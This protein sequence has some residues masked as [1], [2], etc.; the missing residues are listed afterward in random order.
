MVLVILQELLYAIGRFFI[1]PL[2]YVAI[3]FAIFLG[4]RRVKRERKFFHIRIVNGWSE[5]KSVFKIG[6]FASILLSI[7]MIAAGLTL[8]LEL[9]IAISVVTTVMVILFNF[10]F[11]SAVVTWTIAYSLLIWMHA[12][13]SSIEIVGYT[14]TGIDV[15][16]RAITAV[17]IVIG[18]LLIVEGLLISKDGA[19]FASPIVEKTNRGLKSIAYFSKKIWVIPVFFI[20]PSN[21]IEG[22]LPWWP[23]L[24]L[25]SEKFALVLFP[26]VIGFQ[27]V[28]RRLLPA[29]FYPKLGRYVRIL[30]EVV[31][32]GGVISYFD[33]R[34]AYTTVVIAIAIRFALS[35][36]YKVTERKDLYA[37]AP[38]N[39]GAVIAAVLPGSPAEKMG[40]RV[41]EIIKRV[42]GQNVSSERELYEALQ[43]NAAHCKLEVLDVQKEIR[44]TQY[45]V[46]NNDHH[47]IGLLLVQ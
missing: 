2:L 17:A 46:H 23:L 43:I 33:H 6:W 5:L 7:I 13:N 21:V 10:H 31:V 40:L 37:V 27:Q 29:Q 16:S 15:E 38:S 18:L 36:G 22:Y 30:G 45:V 47:Q 25:G 44:L 4:Y 28:T 8:P 19:H 9:L 39:D 11:L 35:F 34:I 42:N 41:G 32:L 20:V 26:V 3:L 12:Q 1:N 14:M 24:P